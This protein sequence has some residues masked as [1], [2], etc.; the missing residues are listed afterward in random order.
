MSEFQENLQK[1]AR[2]NPLL[3]DNYLA[4]IQLQKKR[5]QQYNV[6]LKMVNNVENK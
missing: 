5:A 3:L 1:K 4:I 6:V 2:F